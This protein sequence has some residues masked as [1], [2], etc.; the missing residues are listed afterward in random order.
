VLKKVGNLFFV[1][2]LTTKGKINNKFYHKIQTA[3]FNKNNQ[4]HKD[5]AYCILSQVKAIDKKRF[6]ENI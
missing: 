5:E 2:A 3:T 6:L 4:K 1:V